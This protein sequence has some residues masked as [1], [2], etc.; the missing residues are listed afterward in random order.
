MSELR[1]DGFL[2]GRLQILQ[3][4]RGFRSGPDAVMLAAACPAQGKETVLELGCGAGVASLCLGWRVPT[5]SLTGLEQ[6]ADYAQLARDNADRNGIPLRVV[7]GD[8]AMMP[9]ELRAESFDHVIMNPPYFLAGTAASDQGRAVARQE[10]TSLPDWIDAA[11]KRLRPRGTLTVIQRADRLPAILTALEGRAGGITV[12]PIASRPGREA[13]RIILTAQKGARAP[14]RLLS[15][16]VMH[17]SLQH[18]QDGEDHSAQ[19]SAILRDGKE[20]TTYFTKVS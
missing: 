17:E 12:L 5:L 9:A 2:N 19:A 20:I 1:D 4:I 18:L 11:L 7:H 16:F 3:P 13:G 14:F 8:L 10:S 6:Q 15:S